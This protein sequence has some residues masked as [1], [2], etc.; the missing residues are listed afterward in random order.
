MQSDRRSPEPIQ[1]DRRNSGRP[2]MESRPTSSAKQ[3]VLPSRL[4]LIVLDDC[5]HFP[6]CHL[7]LF[8]FEERYRLMLD[9]ALRTDRMFS[10]G[11]SQ[12]ETEVLPVVTAGLIHA[13]VKN[14]D[15]TSQV[16]LYG[17]HRMHITGWEQVAPFRIARV[18]PML[19]KNAPPENLQ[20]LKSRV[21]EL[22]PNPTDD[23]C[24]NMRQ[25]HQG[26][27]QLSEHEIVCDVIAFH[28]L[29]KKALLRTLLAET[30]PERRYKLL[31]SELEKTRR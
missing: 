11:V 14:P 10:V 18:E 19:S 26:L 28:F 21:L 2:S 24:D 6:G 27:E 8:I 30:C 16:M 1:G 31:I 5:Y 4:P 20:A 25:L 23:S 9:H 17:V 15:G 29:R 13:S 22:L 3:F 7:P 12:G